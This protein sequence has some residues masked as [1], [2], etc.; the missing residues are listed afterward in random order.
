MK[1]SL[2][3][4]GIKYSDKET[5]RDVIDKLGE[6]VVEAALIC[7]IT[8]DNIEEAYSGQFDNDVDFAQDMAEQ[9]GSIDKDASWPQ[10]CIDWEHAAKEIMYDYCE[11]NGYYFRNL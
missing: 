9:T 8:A 4:Q 5:L 7:D 6:E 11:E 3:K 2:L 10:N 1:L